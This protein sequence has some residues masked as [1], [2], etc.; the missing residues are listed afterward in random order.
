MA[1]YS[2]PATLLREGFERFGTGALTEPYARCIVAWL[3]EQGHTAQLVLETAYLPECWYAVYW[4][5]R[6]ADE[7]GLS[8]WWF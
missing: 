6:R 7:A 1:S 5:E 4:K 2:T 8:G 3:Q